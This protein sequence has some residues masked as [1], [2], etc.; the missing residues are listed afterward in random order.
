MET[1]TE[2]VRRFLMH[3][4]LYMA[5]NDKQATEL[6]GADMERI[7]LNIEMQRDSENRKYRIYHAGHNAVIRGETLTA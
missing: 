7:L 2:Y 3:S 6:T 4:E 1:Q 5:M